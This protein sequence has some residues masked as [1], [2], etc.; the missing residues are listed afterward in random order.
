MAA[1]LNLEKCGISQG[2]GSWV[3]KDPILPPVALLQQLC[4]SVS[5]L[6]FY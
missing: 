4:F 3:G 5:N 1:V 6:T 2:Q